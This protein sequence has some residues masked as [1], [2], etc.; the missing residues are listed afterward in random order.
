M[1]Q[2]GLSWSVE[3]EDLE[4]VL[5]SASGYIWKYITARA[6]TAC[7]ETYYPVRF[8]PKGDYGWVSNDRIA[9]LSPSHIAA[10]LDNKVSKDTDKRLYAL[11]K[12]RVINAY[13]MAADP[14]KWLESLAEKE[15]ADVTK[16][17]AKEAGP[18][19]G[20]RSTGPPD[21]LD[22]ATPRRKRNRDEGP[23][24][25]PGTAVPKLIGPK[26]PTVGP[27]SRPEGL[28]IREAAPRRRKIG[29]KSRTTGLARRTGQRERKRAEGENLEAEAESEVENE[30]QVASKT[31]SD[32]DGEELN[33]NLRHQTHRSNRPLSL[34]RPIA[35]RR[36]ILADKT[37]QTRELRRDPRS[38]TARTQSR[39][40]AWA[41]E[42][43]E[44]TDATQLVKWRCD[45][46]AAL[47]PQKDETP[48][49]STELVTEADNIFKSLEW[50]R[51]ITVEYL[52][53]SKLLAVMKRI[54]LA[55]DEWDLRNNE[56]RIR[57][58]A[59]AFVV[60]WEAVLGGRRIED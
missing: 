28:P 37:Q 58:R 42:L 46:Q 10:F 54:S 12:R 16:A 39:R 47:F 36:M 1:S 14:E 7:N 51:E 52:A 5:L 4:S 60:K 55:D 44:D 9:R 53:Y 6:H 23:V 49:R 19:R 15:E 18:K 17:K 24:R 20:S 27:D 3:L 35:K 50:F 56:N 59:A 38:N 43:E 48:E 33:G 57:E 21:A 25:D 22:T 34:Q 26:N 31:Q 8:F 32:E 13:R 30:N 41:K 45:L 11:S 40:G 29:P 2:K